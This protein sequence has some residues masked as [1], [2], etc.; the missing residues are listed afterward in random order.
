MSDYQQ[1]SIIFTPKTLMPNDITRR[2]TSRLFY[3]RVLRALGIRKADNFESVNDDGDIFNDV[4]MSPNV[5]SHEERGLIY[6]ILI[7]SRTLMTTYFR[8]FSLLGEELYL[9]GLLAVANILLS[10]AFLAV[11][12]S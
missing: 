2:G 3:D 12:S 8:A 4:E 10:I 6:N 5:I 9:G 1:P 7:Q 11:E